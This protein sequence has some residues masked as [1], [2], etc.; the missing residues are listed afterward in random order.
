MD[1]HMRNKHPGIAYDFKNGFSMYDDVGRL[2]TY[3]EDDLSAP[4][5]LNKEKTIYF[6]K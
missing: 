1:L 3:D 2:K 5:I 6:Q 4:K